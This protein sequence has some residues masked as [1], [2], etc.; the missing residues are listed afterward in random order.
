MTYINSNYITNSTST[1][2]RTPFHLW[3]ASLALVDRL[4]P[5]SK[6]PNSYKWIPK[7]ILIQTFQSLALS[8]SFS[9]SSLFQASAAAAPWSNDWPLLGA[10]CLALPPTSTLRHWSHLVAAPCKPWRPSMHSSQ[11]TAVGYGWSRDSAERFPQP[12]TWLA[13]RIPRPTKLLAQ[14][15][16]SSAGYGFF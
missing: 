4:A 14:Q 16:S 2:N 1:W 13:G 7:Q 15:V 12:T 8:F 5:P 6:Q 3:P 10:H 11:H 9:L